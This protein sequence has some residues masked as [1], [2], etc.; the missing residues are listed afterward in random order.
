[1]ATFEN[2]VIFSTYYFSYVRNCKTALT[3]GN[4]NLHI[5][6]GSKIRSFSKWIQLEKYIKVQMCPLFFLKVLLVVF[7]SLNFR[8]Y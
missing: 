7:H 3:G 8:K 1:M 2:C 5:L 6:I 4:N